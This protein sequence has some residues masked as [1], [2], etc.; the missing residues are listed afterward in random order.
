MTRDL[1]HRHPRNGSAHHRLEQGLRGHVL[2][3][4]VLQTRSQARDVDAPARRGFEGL[5]VLH[6][7][8][9]EV[10]ELIEH[11]HRQRAG[12]QAGSGKRRDPE[13]VDHGPLP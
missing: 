3:P 7:H 2:L 12:R 5:Q 6:G 9:G 10:R 1:A 13:R 11:R 8:G 4:K